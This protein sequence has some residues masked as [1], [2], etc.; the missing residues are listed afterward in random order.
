M[1][2]VGNQIGIKNRIIPD[3]WE[4]LRYNAVSDSFID[5]LRLHIICMLGEKRW[6]IMYI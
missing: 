1:L 4:L 5:D 6:S 3:Y 2:S